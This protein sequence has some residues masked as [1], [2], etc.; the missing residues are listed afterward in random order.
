MFEKLRRALKKENDTYVKKE[1]IP[2]VES[3][4]ESQVES[5][6]NAVAGKRIKKKIAETPGGGLDAKRTVILSG[7]LKDR[8]TYLDG[9][10]R[11][12]DEAEKAPDIT[13]FRV[14][15]EWKRSRTWG[16]NPTAEMCNGNSFVR[17]TSV[18]GC[19]YDKESTAAA[20]VMNHPDIL[21]ILYKEKEK[22]VTK[23]NRELLGYGSGHWVL[24]WFDGGVGMTSFVNIFRKLG[25]EVSS[26]H[27]KMYDV[28]NFT[29][30]K[31]K[32]NAE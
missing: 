17:G 3:L 20:E 19:G 4:D 11:R 7:R 15:I 27:G 31:R 10:L 24:P 9:L 16:S 14:S 5:L 26:N 22:K 30:G 6:F 2:Y 32:K 18:G 29:K 1:I 8:Q 12:L 28:Y 21:R 13:W 23:K 25:W